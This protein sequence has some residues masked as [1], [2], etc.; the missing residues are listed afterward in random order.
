MDRIRDAIAA[1]PVGAAV[2]DGEAVTFIRDEQA[3]FA[4]LR[5]AAGQ[6]NAILIAY[7]LLDSRARRGETRQ[8]RRSD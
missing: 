4:V 8:D 3:D 7:D 5:T 2:L 6:S 1:L